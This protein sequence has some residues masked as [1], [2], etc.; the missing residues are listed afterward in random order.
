MSTNAQSQ[1][2]LIPKSNWVEFF[3]SQPQASLE[4]LADSGWIQRKPGNKFYT[5]LLD[6]AFYNGVSWEQLDISLPLYGS[7]W[8]AF[9]GDT[10]QEPFL[11]FAYFYIID[12]PPLVNL[13]L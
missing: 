8:F 9:K 11:F 2:K 4:S 1:T 7:N 12:P 6:T 13:L 3:I 5:V 10:A